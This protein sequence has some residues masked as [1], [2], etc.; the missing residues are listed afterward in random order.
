[1][2]TENIWLP[3]R[4]V[5]LG[6]LSAE[7]ET[8]L[9]SL[10]TFRNLTTLPIVPKGIKTW[11]DALMC[12]HLGFPAIYVSNHG[13][14]VLD[15]TP[16]A[17]EVL[18]D[19][20]K[21]APE[22]FS[23]ME[24]YADG[25]VR[26]ATDALILL[27]LGAPMFANIWGEGVSKLIDIFSAEMG[28]SMQ[29]MGVADVAQLNASY[30]SL[31]SFRAKIRQL[32]TSSFWFPYGVADQRTEWWWWS[33]T[34]YARYIAPHE[35]HIPPSPAHSREMHGT[36]CQGCASGISLPPLQERAPQKAQ[37]LQA[38]IHESTIVQAQIAKFKVHMGRAGGDSGGGGGSNGSGSLDS[39][40]GAKVPELAVAP[41][42]EKIP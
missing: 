2:F 11:Q 5:Q 12:L 18:M 20:R 15:G 17:V 25:G 22:V 1:M 9:N 13:G 29:L 40:I 7:F 37:W 14:R 6:T 31:Q 39:P 34:F 28:T 16:T 36:F 19:I 23:R 26:R 27:A 30:H 33:C 4:V 38:N 41:A 32:D 8:L 10:T 24:V 35:R 42:S 21:N 3:L